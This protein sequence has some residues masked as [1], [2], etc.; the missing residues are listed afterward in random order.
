LRSSLKKGAIGCVIYL[1]E[2]GGGGGVGLLLK[3]ESPSEGAKGQYSILETRG[4]AEVPG[5]SPTK[6]KSVKG[7]RLKKER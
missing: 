5:A 2:G 4:V 6:G 1:R 7:A 3:E